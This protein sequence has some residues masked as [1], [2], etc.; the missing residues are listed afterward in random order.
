MTSEA[1]NLTTNWMDAV[2]A[3]IAPYSQQVV[4]YGNLR[5][6]STTWD[7]DSGRVTNVAIVYEVPGGSTNQINITYME[8]TATFAYLALDTHN[9]QLTAALSEVLHMVEE[10][11]VRIPEIRRN[12]LREDIDRWAQQGL[13][14]QELFHEIKKLLQIEDLRGGTI[15]PQEMR[16]SI[17]YIMANYRTVTS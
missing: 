16:E 1:Q 8:S 5:A 17:A 13:G 4:P 6:E 11:I 12:R 3:V 15:T 2:H 10:A 9:E 7:D 14:Q